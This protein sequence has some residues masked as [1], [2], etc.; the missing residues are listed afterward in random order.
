MRLR[1]SKRAKVRG[2]KK[3]EKIEKEEQADRMKE[4]G[5]KYRQTDI[6]GRRG[7]C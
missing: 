1:D 4:K 5:E 3:T 2:K 7:G 6:E